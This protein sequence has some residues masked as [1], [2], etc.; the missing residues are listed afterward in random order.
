MEVTAMRRHVPDDKTPPMASGTERADMRVHVPQPV[1]VRRGAVERRVLVPYR[2]QAAKS[3]FR[4]GFV[5]RAAIAAH[6]AID[7]G[8]TGDRGGGTKFDAHRF[9][10]S[11]VQGSRPT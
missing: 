11:R 10:N 2:L 7:V 9:G 3:T 6:K 1:D 4:I 8:R 5:P